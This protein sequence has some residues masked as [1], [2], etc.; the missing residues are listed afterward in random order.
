MTQA[1]LTA[2]TNP[3]NG[4]VVFNSDNNKLYIYILT[5]NKWQEVQYGTGEIVL[6]ASYT[7]GTGGLCSSTTINGGY[8]AGIALGTGNAVTMNANVT[9]AGSWSITTN[10]ANGYSF[11]G[12]GNFTSTGTKQVTLYGSGI[13]VTD[14][15]DSF[16]ATA[17]NGGGTCS[18][19]I[20]VTTLSATDVYNPISGQTWMDR[21]LGASQVATS[22]SDPDAYGDLY[23]WGRFTEGHES[24]TSLTTA[25]NATTPTPNA[26]NP[27]DGLFITENTTPYDWLI[28]QDN[29]LWQG[30]YS[31][32]KP[33]PDGYR[34]PTDPEWQA[35]RASWASNNA[36][37]AYGS[38]LK[39]T[40][41]GYR[42]NYNGTLYY[43]GSYARYWSSTV[44]GTNARGLL[45]NST[46]ASM[47][48]LFR[49]Y[50]FSVRCIKD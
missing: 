29:T 31:P 44:I 37:G 35:E 24:R 27:W 16:I 50:G 3:A 4:L 15:T 47:G 13:P 21:N 36:A 9:T 38:P 5:F 40:V 45:F 10:T 43:V 26:G 49:A 6:P 19:D 14:Q 7:I 34:L 25:I 12:S 39:L 17:N 42:G 8:Y 23:Q 28:S 11:S 2:I 41:G 30:T 46:G 20:T 48:S 1:Q 22:S 32:N 18:F 33:C